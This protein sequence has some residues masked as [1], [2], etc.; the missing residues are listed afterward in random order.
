ML[1]TSTGLN[2]STFLQNIDIPWNING[3]LG[4]FPGKF[5]GIPILGNSPEN[6]GESRHIRVNPGILGGKPRSIGGNP[7]IF[8]QYSTKHTNIPPEL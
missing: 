8:Q 1:C 5:G 2:S 6:W 3:I 7:R 4:V